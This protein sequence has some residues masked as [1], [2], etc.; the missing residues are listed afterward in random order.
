MRKP[1]H[2]ITLLDPDHPLETP[3]GLDPERHL[4]LGVHDINESVEGLTPPDEAAV[5]RIIGFGRGWDAERP[6]LIHCWA[7]I[8]RSTATAFTLACD[9][10]PDVSEAEIAREIRRRSRFAWP[11]RRIVALADWILGRRG[12]MVEAVEDMGAREV[13]YEGEPFELNARW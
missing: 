5:L 13:A 7:G 9:K 3:Q 10:N 12:R 4:K 1:S 2:L 11:N 8:S 6:I